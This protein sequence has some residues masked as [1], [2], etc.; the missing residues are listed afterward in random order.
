MYSDISAVGSQSHTKRFQ[1]ILLN[2]SVGDKSLSYTVLSAAYIKGIETFVIS[3]NISNSLTILPMPKS[4]YNKII[5][6]ADL[7]ILN[8]VARAAGVD[9]D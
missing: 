6:R 5:T 7:R 3:P 1:R 8:S 9:M 2:A 4:Y